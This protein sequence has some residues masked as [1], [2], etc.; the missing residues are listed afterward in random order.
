[1]LASCKHFFF[2]VKMDVLYKAASLFKE[3]LDTEYVFVL[4]KKNVEATIHLIFQERHFPHLAGLQHLPDLVFLKQDNRIIFNEI[5]NR[6]IKIEDIQKSLFYTRRKSIN[7]RRL[8]KFCSVIK[9]LR[10]KWL[11]DA[12]CLKMQSV[13]S[14]PRQF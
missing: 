9:I 7:Q 2:G 3:L 14:F 11:S 10:D 5:I 6:S 12:V 4:G 13:C 8:K 1:M